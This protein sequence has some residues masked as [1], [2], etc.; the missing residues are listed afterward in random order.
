MSGSILGM[1]LVRFL[2]PQ[3]V[4]AIPADGLVAWYTMEKVSGSYLLDETGNYNGVIYG[5]TD[6]GGALYFDGSTDR[7]DNDCPAKIQEFAWFLDIE[8]DNLSPSSVV[9][10]TVGGYGAV[11]LRSTDSGDGLRFQVY[12]AP[13]TT[14]IMTA[15]I[16]VRYRI[17]CQHNGSSTE[18]WVNGVLVDSAT[19]AGSILY[20]GGEIG[21]RLGAEWGLNSGRYFYGRIFEFIEY[22]RLLTPNEIDEHFS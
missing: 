9:C 1:A 22:E 3:T 10:A 13:Y 16:G 17:V 15:S 5:A 14:L 4:G 18:L 12:N 2:K 7:V 20:Q 6:I 8:I 11:I 19:N 21:R